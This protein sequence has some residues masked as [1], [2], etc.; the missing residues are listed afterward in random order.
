M[1]DLVNQGKE[2]IMLPFYVK[3][4]L[5][6]LI[7]AGFEAYAVGGAVR[8]L[9]LG[10]TPTD[11]DLTTSAYP[12]AVMKLFKKALPTGLKH[13]TVTVVTDSGNV[14]V[15]TFRSEFG[16][17]DSRRPDSVKFGVSLQEDIK[18]RDFTVN[19]LCMDINGN[20][21]DLAGGKEDIE[22]KLIRTVGVPS[23]RFGE[24]A[25][26]ILR[27][28]RF[29]AELGFSIEVET[30]K[31][32]RRDYPLLENI[33]AE[34]I[35]EEFFKIICAPYAYNVLLK[36]EEVFK[37]IFPEIRLEKISY[38][39]KLPPL[40]EYRLSLLF[41]KDEYRSVLRRLKVKNETIGRVEAIKDCDPICLSTAERLRLFAAENGRERTDSA[42]RFYSVF[43]PEYADIYEKTRDSFVTMEDL[44]IGGDEIR[45][46]GFDGPEIGAVKKRL[47]RY[48][49][50][51]KVENKRDDLIRFIEKPRESR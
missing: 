40:P 20:I 1:F 43:K 44:D 36:F 15:T 14:E 33:S 41:G 48:I 29:S 42:V 26:R 7:S 25:L 12:E 45:A 3:E 2:F 13:G 37:G 30:D 21:I 32:L 11:Y 22:K 38:L 24:D 10:K 27:A 17:S 35:R 39:E 34:R 47:L 46:L 4:I 18:R 6:T 5:E 51:A 49:A 31:A 9:C 50:E 16:Y 8:D 19:A 28:L 23:E